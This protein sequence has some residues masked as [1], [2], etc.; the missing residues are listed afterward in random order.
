MRPSIGF[1]VEFHC[2]A[3]PIAPR[4]V[5]IG[6]WVSEFVIAKFWKHRLRIDVV[7]DR[8]L[9]IRFSQFEIGWHP[10]G[11]AFRRNAPHRSLHLLNSISKILIYRGGLSEVSYASTDI[12]DSADSSAFFALPLTISF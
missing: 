6:P 5:P 10:F 12:A 7:I 9:D 3:H 8:E 4:C 2:P 1:A 11:T